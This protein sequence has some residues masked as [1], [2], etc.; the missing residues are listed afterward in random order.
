MRM[1]FKKLDLHLWVETRGLMRNK[2]SN[3]IDSDREH[4]QHRNRDPNHTDLDH[5]H[6]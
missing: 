6:R 4:P 2:V 1:L 3:N 5:S